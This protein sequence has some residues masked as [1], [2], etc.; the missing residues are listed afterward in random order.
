YTLHWVLRHRP[1]MLG[2]FFLVMGV[3]VYFY[4]IVPKGFIPDTD[5]DSFG[6]QTE[7]VQGTSYFEMARL[8][9]R[10]ARVLLTDPDIESFFSSTG[11]GGGGG[12]NTGRFQ[13]N[14]KPRRQRK[15]TVV[16]IVNRIRP[17]ISNFPGIRAF[18]SIPQ[19]IRVGGR[20]QKSAF[21]Y[22][23]YGP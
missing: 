22:T 9:E 17:K 14:L 11:G 10:V 3:T 19:A 23:L 12:A 16:D 1:I 6:V 2:C 8:N 15:A 21:D 5:N 7:S 4:V 13:I 20:M 18:A